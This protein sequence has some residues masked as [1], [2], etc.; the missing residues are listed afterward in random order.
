MAMP[1]SATMPGTAEVAL[2]PRETASDVC[3]RGAMLREAPSLRQPAKTVGTTTSSNKKIMPAAMLSAPGDFAS[4]PIV[5]SS[6]SLAANDG[7]Q[8]RRCHF[9]LSRMCYILNHAIAS[10]QP[11]FWVRAVL[12]LPGRG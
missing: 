4:W 3:A 5:L 1:V 7:Q 2:L 8:T 9:M 12:P 10:A 11:L 6:P